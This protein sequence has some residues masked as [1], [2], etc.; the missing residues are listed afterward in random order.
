MYH[1]SNFFEGASGSPGIL[2]L[3]GRKMLVL[4][5]TRGFYIPG[6]N[7]PVIEQGVLFTE[8][9]KHVKRCIENANQELYGQNVSVTLNDIFPGVVYAWPELLNDAY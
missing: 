1:V 7:R 6:A 8:I 2:F 5:H 4:V 3:N 9:I